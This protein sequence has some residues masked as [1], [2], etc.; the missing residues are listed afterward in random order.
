ME[1][2]VSGNSSSVEKKDGYEDHE[3]EYKART[4]LEA[5]EIKADAKLMAALQPYLEKKAKAIT[6]IADLRK[7]ASK[8]LKEKSNV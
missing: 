8:K 5:E 4:L 2:T 3:L 6:S 7:V 1:A